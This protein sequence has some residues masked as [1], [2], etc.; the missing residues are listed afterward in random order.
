[1]ADPETPLDARV[2]ALEH[3]VAA[4]R[5]RIATLEGII[6]GLPEHGVDKSATRG[7]V[8]YDWQAPHP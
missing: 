4:L 7:K 1:M 8:V 6:A 5:R 3:E 2:A